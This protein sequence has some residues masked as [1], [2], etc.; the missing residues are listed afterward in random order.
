MSEIISKADIESLFTNLGFKQTDG[1]H[2]T[3]KFY[4]HF[5]ERAIHKFDFGLEIVAIAT[6]RALRSITSYSDQLLPPPVL[7]F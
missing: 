2:R 6:R 5:L 3:L 1:I 7:S 4:L